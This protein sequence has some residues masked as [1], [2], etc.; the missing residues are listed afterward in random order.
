MGQHSKRNAAVFV[1]SLILIARATAE[2][3]GTVFLLSGLQPPGATFLLQVVL[4]GLLVVII[5]RLADVEQ[6][7]GIDGRISK[8]TSVLSITFK[9][10][11][12]F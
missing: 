10:W 3:Q 8:L 9:H 12:I 6:Q 11:N 4:G 5:E 2:K 7:A 1:A